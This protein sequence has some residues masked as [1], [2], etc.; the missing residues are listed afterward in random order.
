MTRLQVQI[1]GDLGP[2]LEALVDRLAL[3]RVADEAQSS[4]PLLI[5]LPAPCPNPP[6]KGGV[7]GLVAPGTDPKHALE[8][9]DTWTTAGGS[10]LYIADEEAPKNWSPAS[11]RHRLGP[12]NAATGSRG[13]RKPGGWSRYYKAPGWVLGCGIC[14]MGD[15]N[16][17]LWLGAS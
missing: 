9:M 17:P 2:E 15:S 1:G 5:R 12:N 11:W 7:I 10:L 13:S 14:P 6:P 8:L 16:F 3:D 4:A